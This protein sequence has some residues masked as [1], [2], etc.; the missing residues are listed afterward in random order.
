VEQTEL[1]QSIF[2]APVPGASVATSE[3]A[4]KPP[5]SGDDE[6][7]TDANDAANRGQKRTRDSED[8]SDEDVAMEEDSDDE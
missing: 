8:E 6:T 4:S 7:M 5:A 3:A 1:Q 2:N